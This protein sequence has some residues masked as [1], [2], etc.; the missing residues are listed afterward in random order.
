MAEASVRK[1]KELQAFIDKGLWEDLTWSDLWDRN[2][3]VRPNREALVDRKSRYTWRQ[4][5]QA[6][7]RLALGFMNLGY[8]KDDAIVVELPG[9]AECMLIR[10]ACDK[11]G[12]LVA[13]VLRSF[14]EFEMKHTLGLLEAKGVV[15][16]YK[17]RDFDYYNMIQSIRPELPKLEHIF[18]VGD[19]VPKGC[20]SIKKMMQ[21][22][23]EKKYAPA[24]LG[25]LFK[26]T[27][28]P[29]T[30]VSELSHTTGTTGVPKLAEWPAVLGITRTKDTTKKLGITSK[31]VLG[32]LAPGWGGMNNPVFHGG[33]YVGAKIVILEHWDTPEA[34]NLIE[35][36]KIT[37]F[38]ITPTMLRQMIDQPDFGKYN[39]SS[40]RCIMVSGAPCPPG[41]PREAEEKF[42][43]KLINTYGSRDLGS[44]ASPSVVDQPEV[45]WATAGK[46]NSWDKIHLLDDK[47]KEVSKG[48]VGEVAVEA[49]TGSAGYFKNPEAT[50]EALSADGL[51]HI[52]D[53]ARFDKSGNLVIV[54]RSKNIIIRGGEN[55]YPTEIEGILGVHP[56]VV[57]AAVVKMP[58]PLFGERACAYVALKPGEKFTLDEM[59]SFLKQKGIAAFKLPERLE[60]VDKIPMVGD[61]TKVDLKTLE[62]EIANKLKAEGKI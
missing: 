52:G 3:R 60:I 6:I 29:S 14:R 42:G 44:T 16:P 7:N 57:Q 54:G 11:A 19:E 41:W 9:W 5:K 58:D 47:G 55:I 38:A 8:K 51:F 36:E 43:A 4:A 53:L 59:V 17:W 40:L 30:E 35:K 13:P 24:Q 26:K 23:L 18:I 28:M 21:E 61:G 31:D 62:K 33:P 45:R 48:G 15:I 39:L 2:A 34:F 22:P 20:I 32:A 27:K 1:K 49:V 50:K 12:L 37:Y 25:K 46:S 56:K 10:I